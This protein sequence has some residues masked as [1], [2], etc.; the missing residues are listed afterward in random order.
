MARPKKIQ[1]DTPDEM[2][3]DA[4]DVEEQKPEPKPVIRRRF[5][6]TKKCFHNKTLY[7]RGRTAKFHRPEDGPQDK[8]GNLVNFEEIF[9]GDTI[10]VPLV[11][12]TVN[13]VET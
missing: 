13:K 1:E 8:E 9:P 7:H 2:G 12:V 10:N 5:V 11:G 3:V 4:K 6:C